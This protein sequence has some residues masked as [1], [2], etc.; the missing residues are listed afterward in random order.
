MVQLLQN[1]LDECQEP[2]LKLFQEHCLEIIS[3]NMSKGLPTMGYRIFLQILARSNPEITLQN[4]KIFLI[5]QAT[6]KSRPDACLT[7]LWIVSQSMTNNVSYSFKLWQEI[8][9][10][11]L[12]LK[13]FTKYCMQILERLVTLRYISDVLHHFAAH[14]SYICLFQ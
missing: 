14:L 5:H 1:L 8:F 9:F 6:I 10:P 13:Q 4:S 12:T 11:L 7:L 2:T 3:K